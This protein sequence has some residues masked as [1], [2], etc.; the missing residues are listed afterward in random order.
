MR[1]DLAFKCLDSA[2][3][4]SSISEVTVKKLLKFVNGCKVNNDT[5]SNSNNI[6]D[7]QQ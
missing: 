2:Y 3:L 1:E 5:Y 7:S 6:F 4:L